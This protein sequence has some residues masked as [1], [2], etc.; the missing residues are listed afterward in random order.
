MSK[1]LLLLAALLIVAV[2]AIGQDLIGGDAPIGPPGI[3]VEPLG[4][5]IS[6]S[7]VRP[8]NNGRVGGSVTYATPEPSSI[9]LAGA[10]AAGLLGWSLLRRRRKS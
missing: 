6:E 4:D 8:A 10:G 5:P 1:L 9:A 7:F 2:P 3:G